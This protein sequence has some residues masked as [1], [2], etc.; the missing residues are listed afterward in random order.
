MKV[1]ADGR[2]SRGQG[3]CLNSKIGYTEVHFSD[4]GDR[5]GPIGRGRDREKK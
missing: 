5:V 1:P 2:S 3:Q 4:R